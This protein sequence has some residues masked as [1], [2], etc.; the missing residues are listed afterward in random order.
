MKRQSD[1]KVQLELNI[2]EIA[3][4]FAAL[5]T[6]ASERMN[7]QWRKIGSNL[8]EKLNDC[9]EAVHKSRKT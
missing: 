1:G 3:F 6:V 7:P 9:N 4:L 2:Q 5:S 8:W